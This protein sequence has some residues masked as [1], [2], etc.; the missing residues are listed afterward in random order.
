MSKK[1]KRRS[2][3]GLGFFS[4]LFLIF[5]V[6]KLGVGDTGV[7]AWSWWWV[8]A[9]LWGPALLAAVCLAL[10]GLCTWIANKLETPEEKAARK[11]RE[12]M[13]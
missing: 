2:G 7:T 12:L 11:I 5:L 8:T 4:I 9:P 10:A 3:N 1:S 6:L 13:R